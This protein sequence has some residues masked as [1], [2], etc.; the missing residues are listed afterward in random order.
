MKLG[1]A[2][3]LCRRNNI[4]LRGTFFRQNNSGFKFEKRNYN[5]TSNSYFASK[6]NNLP[7]VEFSL[8]H[9]C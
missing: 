3:R 2:A 1:V 8:L 5:A 7:L 4:V 6:N 9:G